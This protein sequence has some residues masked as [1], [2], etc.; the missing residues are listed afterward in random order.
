MISSFS[1]T[2]VLYGWHISQD[3]L[4]P[5]IKSKQTYV[6]FVKH[7]YGGD[8]TYIKEQIYEALVLVTQ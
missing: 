4:S 7:E 5:N 6:C 2:I 3:M 8:L 1:I